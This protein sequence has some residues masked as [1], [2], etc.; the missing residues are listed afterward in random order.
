MEVAISKFRAHLSDCIDK[1]RSGDE[2]V[3]TDRGTPVA[4]LV[5]V[6]SAPVLEELVRRG[7]VSPPV[8]TARPAARTAARAHAI[9]SV[10]DLVGDQRR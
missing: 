5:P 7:I 4:R 3:I 10:S 1:V 8:N 6:D 2:V 9:G